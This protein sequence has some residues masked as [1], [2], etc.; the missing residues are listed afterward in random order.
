MGA[1]ATNPYAGQPLAQNVQGAYTTALGQSGALPGA[2]AGALGTAD[3]LGSQAAGLYGAMGGMTPSDVTAGQLSSTDLSP[4]MNPFTQNVIDS[5]MGELRKQEDISQQGVDDAAL[6]Q[7]AFGGDRMYIQKAAMNNNFN[8]LRKNTIAD[9][10]SKN[11]LNA[12]T[13]GMGDIGNR[14]TADTGNADRRAG[15]SQTG[16]QGLGALADL[17]ARS[18][19][20]LT[21]FGISN[22]GDLANMGFGFGDTLQKNQLTAGLM[23][24]NQNQMILDAIR[25]QY[26][27]YTG[28]PQNALQNYLASIQNTAGY[29]TKTGTTTPGLTDYMTATGGL[30]QGAGSMIPGPTP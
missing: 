16:A 10:Y 11:F 21:K 20:D 4:Y 1:P 23:Q 29:G 24:Q 13:M 18:G 19:G 5:T 7:K 9:L 8:N 3:Q 6:G 14:L 12:Q 15:M 2:A 28:A 30:L 17:F 26:G 22:L 27:G 25:A